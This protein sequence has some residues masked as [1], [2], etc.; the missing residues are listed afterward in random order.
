MSPVANPEEAK[1]AFS[2]QIVQGESPS[3]HTTLL[4]FRP[5]GTFPVLTSVRTL[6]FDRLALKCPPV[7]RL[8][9]PYPRSTQ[10]SPK[11]V[12]PASPSEWLNGPLQPVRLPSP[13]L[14][15]PRSLHRNTVGPNNRCQYGPGGCGQS[16]CFQTRSISA[17]RALL[18]RASEKPRKMIVP[19]GI[20]F[21]PGNSAV[22]RD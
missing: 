6:R 19:R 7:K 11:R 15:S 22:N 5:I 12:G 17:G 3:C 1:F 8:R 13:L 2:S 4:F 16:D 18:P 9:E 10:C 14:R 20:C 21:I